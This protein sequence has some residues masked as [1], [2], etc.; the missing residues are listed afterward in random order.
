MGAETRAT[1][2]ALGAFATLVLLFLFIPIAIIVV[3]AFNRSNVQSWPPPGL[4]TKWFGPT[5]HND[6]ARNAFV[7]SVKA[8][9][10]ATGIALVLG[11]MAAF[12]VHRF[13]FFGCE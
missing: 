1:R 6:D 10:L 9:A 12:A 8:G 7:L 2:W 5:W 13:R 3:Y 11:T 4:S